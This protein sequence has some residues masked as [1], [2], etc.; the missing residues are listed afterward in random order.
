FINGEDVRHVLLYEDEF[1]TAFPVGNTF[2]ILF[3]DAVFQIRSYQIDLVIEINLSKETFGNFEITDM[4][5]DEHTTLAVVHH[6]PEVVYP[7]E[8]IGKP[9]TQ[10]GANCSFIDNGL[11]KN[12]TT[13]ENP[14]SCFHRIPT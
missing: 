11:A 1:N 2:E 4:R 5:T 6:F 8:L 14:K 13:P 10:S 3:Y 12:E 9:V 7:V